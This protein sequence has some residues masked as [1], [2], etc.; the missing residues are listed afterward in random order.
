MSEGGGAPVVLALGRRG[1]AFASRAVVAAAAA[2]VEVVAAAVSAPP[3]AA[4]ARRAAAAG[5]GVSRVPPCSDAPHAVL[6][7]GKQPHNRVA[8]G[9]RVL[10]V[11]VELP[12]LREL[13]TGSDCLT[14]W[15]VVRISPTPIAARGAASA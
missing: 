6:A 12:L 7:D 4:G 14:V 5:G 13:G 11:L 15:R 3:A 1:L 10:D 9:Q 2:A 8:D